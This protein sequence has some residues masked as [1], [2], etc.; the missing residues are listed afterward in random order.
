MLCFISSGC[1][2]RGECGFRATN[3]ARHEY[4]RNFANVF[5]GEVVA[6]SF[7]MRTGLFVDLIDMHIER[8]VLDFLPERRTIVTM[9]QHSAGSK[10]HIV[11]RKVIRDLTEE[12]SQ[13]FWFRA[14]HC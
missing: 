3:I 14:T 11:S 10:I 2:W 4:F 6:H 7:V 13:L 1:N 5:V 9:V 8:C 12:G